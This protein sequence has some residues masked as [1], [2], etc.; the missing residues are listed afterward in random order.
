MNVG[1]GG[2]RFRGV[3]TQGAL[4]SGA[5]LF[6]VV[7]THHNMNTAIVSSK[8]RRRLVLKPGLRTATA[9]DHV[10]V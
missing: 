4:G 9:E 7:T 6:C 1:R 5:L 8:T 2:Q 10:I 3:G